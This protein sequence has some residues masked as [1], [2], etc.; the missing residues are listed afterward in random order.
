MH[1]G[2][3]DVDATLAAGAS[4]N[5]AG[6]CL[7]GRYTPLAA[8]VRNDAVRARLLAAGADVNAGRAMHYAAGWGPAAALTD[9]IHHGGDVNVGAR[10]RRPPVFMC[11]RHR[12]VE[13]LAVLLV[14]P[15]LDLDVTSAAG[16]TPLEYAAMVGD[17]D[18]TAMIRCEVTASVRWWEVF[19][20]LMDNF[21]MIVVN[22]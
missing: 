2:V 7:A 17:D 22:V 6:S 4:V 1:R 10:E 11:L 5:A 8:A 14:Q 21:G 16:Y 3:A 18:A 13:C 9:F 20:K 19:G 12:N 15:E